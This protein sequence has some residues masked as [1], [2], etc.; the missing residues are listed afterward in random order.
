M[1][2][3]FREQALLP[4]DELLQIPTEY[5]L[6]LVRQSWILPTAVT[7]VR[8][9]ERNQYTGKVLMRWVAAALCVTT[10]ISACKYRRWLRPP[11]ADKL[12]AKIA[13]SRP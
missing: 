5:Q 1:F 3:G 12:A 9:A 13:W 10:M 4:L 7:A 11:H 2:L 8:A 6:G